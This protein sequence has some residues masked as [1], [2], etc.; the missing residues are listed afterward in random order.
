[1]ILPSK[2]KHAFLIQ[3]VLETEGCFCCLVD[4][5]W[6]TLVTPWTV[7]LACLLSHF[8]HF[9]LWATVWAVAHQA[10][11][12]MGFSRQEYW[13]RL[14]CPSP[15][16]LPNPGIELAWRLFLALAGGFVTTSATW[17]A[18]WTVQPRLI[19]LLGVC[20]THTCHQR[21]GV[22]VTHRPGRHSLRGVSAH[23]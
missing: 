5:S 15:G 19:Q 8:S 1:M 12:P 11:L 4:K 9:Q 6:P 22:P 21:A 2:G 3:F 23:S 18:P 20:R 14:P 16:D 17:E 13:S 7:L 10:P